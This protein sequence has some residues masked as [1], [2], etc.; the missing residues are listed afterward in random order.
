MTTPIAPTGEQWTI[1]PATSRSSSSRSGA[2]CASFTDAGRDVLW[3][4]GEQEE[5]RAG[6]GQLLMPW[7]NRITDGRYERDGRA[8]QLA[9]TEPARHNAIHGLVRWATWTVVEHREDRITV[10]HRL[11]PQQGWSWT[12]ELTVTYLLDEQGLPS[13]ARAQ[14]RRR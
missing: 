6:R 14:H 10:G 7:P 12:L 8:Q 2:G 11:H 3:G 9:L 1:A 13:P 5:C 4:F